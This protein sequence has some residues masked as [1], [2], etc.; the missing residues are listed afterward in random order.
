MPLSGCWV[1]VSGRRP[2]DSILP[3][4]VEDLTLHVDGRRLID[5]GELEIQ[6]GGPTIILGPN[7]A[8]KSLILRML[9][10]LVAPTGGRIL[11]A[12]FAAT[13]AIQMR[14]SMVFQKPVLLRR[15]VAANLR[16]VLRASAI[17][18]DKHASLVQQALD[19]ANMLEKAS[20]QART[21]SGGE[22][23]L[24]ALMRAL[25]TRPEVLFLDEPTSSLDPGITQ[26][27]ERRILQ[28]AAAGTKIIMVSHDLGQAQRL[29]DEVLFCH[30]GCIIEQTA[31]PRFF[32][33][34]TTREA[35]Q[36]IKGELVI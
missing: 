8:G 16:Y 20:Q 36:F 12:G 27:I 23:Q 30:Q 5:L 7:G 26:M 17:P 3:I 11:F 14:Q 21:L 6:S 18:R 4:T 29:A 13:R 10:G 28:A 2:M 22:Q 15:S 33:Q 32:T 31:A 25:I 9:H 24:L 1:R 19:D 34:P 35:A